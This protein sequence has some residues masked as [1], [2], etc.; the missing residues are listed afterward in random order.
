MR[1]SACLIVKNE[2]DHIKAVLESLK[3]FDEIVVV[4]TGSEDETV[5]LAREYTDKVFTDYVW[6][7]DF[8][9]ARNHALA[10][11]TGD[12]V[13]SIDGDEILDP[14]GLEKIK[15]IINETD[16]K[17]FSVVMKNGNFTHNLAR[18]FRN[19]GTV[20]WVGRAHETLAPIQDNRTDIVIEYGYSTAHKKD[21]DRMLRILTKAVEENPKSPRDIYYLARE[22][23]YRKQYNEAISLLLEYVK[24][25][26]WNPELADGY[27]YLARCYFY[28]FQGDKAREACLKCIQ[29]NPDFKEALLFMADLHYEPW[30]EKWLQFAGLATNKN[31]LFIRESSKKSDKPLDMADIDIQYFKNILLRYSSP[32]VLEW[33]SGTSTKYF[34]DFLRENKKEYSWVSIEH[35]KGWYETVKKWNLPA[36]DVRFAE[37]GSDAYFDVKGKYDVIFIDGRNRRKCLLKAKELLNENGVVFLHDGDRKYYQCAFEGYH[38]KFI[39]DEKRALPRLWKGTLKPEEQKIPKIIHQIWIGEK[40]APEDLIKGWKEKH[41]DWLHILWDE[42]M[43][44]QFKMK[45]RKL[46]DTYY[47]AGKYSGAANVLRVEL[48]QH[49]GGVY[50]DADSECVTPIDGAP[51]L[52]WDVFG[53]Y[54]ADNFFV[55]GVKLIANGIMGCI[56]N[57]P[58]MAVYIDKLSKLTEIYPTW[59]MSGPLLWSTIGVKEHSILPAYTFLPVHHSGVKNK[60]EGTVY[61]NQ[62]WGTTKNL[63]GTSP[64]RPE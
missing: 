23:Y 8:A 6:N 24:I 15:R 63:Y 47:K 2:K 18:I 7:D 55:D 42:E 62:L 11:C 46:Y 36:V 53:L 26:R 19:D 29:I 30:R 20:K 60:I 44:D 34:T 27:L 13:L 31:V 10:K 16:K 59:R 61:A 58:L 48:L 3:G 32:K 64:T 38:H 17:T 39:Q 4:D 35:H 43:I 52:D 5:S 12:W 51:F 40:Q 41:P 1:I 9:E 25:G 56:P 28:T 54:E 57:H 14:K 22:K 45:N 50:L 37:Q 21:P 49:Y 33:G